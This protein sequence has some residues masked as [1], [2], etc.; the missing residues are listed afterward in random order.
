MKL[1]KGSQFTKEN[2]HMAEGRKEGREGGRKEG[3]SVINSQIIKLE[4]LLCS[5]HQIAKIQK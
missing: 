1:V 2:T 5:T 4:K 3:S